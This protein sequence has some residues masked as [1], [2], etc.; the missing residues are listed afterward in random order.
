VGLTDGNERYLEQR[1]IEG[2]IAFL[3]SIEPHRAAQFAGMYDDAI[4]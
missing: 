3:H 1:R 2:W 4:A